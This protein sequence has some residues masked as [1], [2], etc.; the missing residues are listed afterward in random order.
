[1][2][3]IFPN[4]IQAHLLQHYDQESL[5]RLSACLSRPPQSLCVRVNTARTEAL[6]FL[7]KLRNVLEEIADSSSRGWVCNI[8]PIIADAVF[9]RLPEEAA[10]AAD[11]ISR[12]DK[13]CGREVVV[14]RKCGEGVL[15]GADVFVPG[16]LSTSRK[17]AAKDIVTVLC[18]VEDQLCRGCSTEILSTHTI[19]PKSLKGKQKPRMK[20]TS[21]HL[22][23]AHRSEDLVPRE[24]EPTADGLGEL[25]DGILLLGYGQLELTRSDIFS[26]RKGLA[27]R[28]LHTQLPFPPMNGLLPDLMYLQNFP[29]I[30]TA[31]V[32]GPQ[33]GERILDMCA[34]PGGKASHLAA[35]LRGTGEV[36]AL[37]RSASKVAEIRQLAA[38]LNLRNLSA[39]CCDATLAVA[40]SGAAAGPLVKAGKQVHVTFEPESFDCVLLD[41]PC[42]ALGLRPRLK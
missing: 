38:R 19:S 2:A 7:P 27:V 6:A 29:S 24:H 9:I 32:L 33:A 28:M 11:G 20:P 42:S 34:A 21:E 15:R 35:L 10:L 30:V 37:D 4:D 26:R 3:Q 5:D 14:S 18:D 13:S 1:M 12:P 23:H 41:A 36:V 40:A 22:D 8:D 17:A 31:H 39:Y 25:P 16:V